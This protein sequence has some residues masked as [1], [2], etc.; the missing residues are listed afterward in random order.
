V[1][2]ARTALRIAA[3]EALAPTGAAAWP[4]IAEGRVFDSRLTPVD[5]TG[6]ERAPCIAV[7]TEHDNR[8]PA[9]GYG[10]PW[11]RTIELRVELMVL[12]A[13]KAEHGDGYVI[14]SPL[15]DAETEADLDLLEEEALFALTMGPS[16]ALLRRFFGN[17]V[18]DVQS[19]PERDAEDGVRLATRGLRLK[20]L[21]PETCPRIEISGS[22][23]AA[24]L[25]RLPEPLR[26]LSLALPAGSYGLGLATAIAARKPSTVEADPLARVAAVPPADLGAEPLAGAIPVGLS[27]DTTGD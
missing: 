16:G 2:L 20:Y 6:G 17:L 9:Q 23:P 19:V 15:T 8:D 10:P 21:V 18:G 7:Y 13:V 25:D 27:L 4:T 1:S 22:P 14:G 24:G 11:K 26:S 3:V 12:Q 5:W